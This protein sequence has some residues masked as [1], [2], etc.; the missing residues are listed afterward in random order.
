MV[1]H[2]YPPL[3]KYL[4]YTISTENSGEPN[5]LAIVNFKDYGMYP[6]KD[7]D[8]EQMLGILM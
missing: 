8:L 1:I 2:D 3:K 5:L 6:V 4:H 7:L